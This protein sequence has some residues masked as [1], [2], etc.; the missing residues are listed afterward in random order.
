MNEL[1][2]ACANCPAPKAT[3]PA[4]TIPAAPNVGSAVPIKTDPVRAPATSPTKAPV[5]A[6]AAGV[7]ESPV[8]DDAQPEIPAGKLPRKMSNPNIESL[9]TLRTL[10]SNPRFKA[11]PAT[12]ETAPTPV[13][14]PPGM[15][16]KPCEKFISAFRCTALQKAGELNAGTEDDIGFSHKFSQL[17]DFRETLFNQRVVIRRPLYSSTRGSVS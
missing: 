9:L 17:P 5:N 1:V 10:A 11:M 14:A 12:P 3:M 15:L 13:A 6:A 2:Y 8:V 16:S 4:P 7:G